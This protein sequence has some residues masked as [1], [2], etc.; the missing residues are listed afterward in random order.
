MCEKDNALPL[1]AQEGLLAS[2]DVEFDV[3]RCNAGH[4]P[5][6]SQPQFVADAIRRAAGA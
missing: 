1:A 2:T 4:S 5:F 6:V 3:V